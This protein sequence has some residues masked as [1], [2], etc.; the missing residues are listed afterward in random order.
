MSRSAARLSNESGFDYA[1]VPP[2]NGG[3]TSFKVAILEEAHDV[4]RLWG[5][6]AEECGYWWTMSPN[7]DVV[8]SNITLSEEE[9]DYAGTCP[10]WNNGTNVTRCTLPIGTAVVVGP[11][12][13]VTCPTG[14][15]IVPKPYPLSLNGDVCGMTNV[16]CVS[17]ETGTTIEPDCVIFAPDPAPASSQAPAP[18]SEAF[19]KASQSKREQ[20]IIQRVAKAVA[21]SQKEPA[22]KAQGARRLPVLAS[23]SDGSASDDSSLAAKRRRKKNVPYSDEEKRMLL[24]GIKK[25]GAGN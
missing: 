11:G 23:D 8:P 16:T 25:Y 5:G 6:P 17:C 18:S 4:Y 12:Q 14:E 24:E 10:S 7:D 2:G 1:W 22:R 3:V 15:E 13:S 21:A 20:F 19:S 9:Y